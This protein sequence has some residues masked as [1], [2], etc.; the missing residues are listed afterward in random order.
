[1]YLHSRNERGAGNAYY[2][3]LLIILIV[4]AFFLSCDFGLLSGGICDRVEGVVG[5]ISQKVNSWVSIKY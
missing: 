4:V 1:M 5:K 2:I 3:L